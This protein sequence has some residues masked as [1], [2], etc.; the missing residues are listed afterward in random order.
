MP[1]HGYSLLPSYVRAIRRNAI[2]LFRR[3]LARNAEI[4]DRPRDARLHRALE[5]EHRR[6]VDEVPMYFLPIPL[7]SA[8]R[9]MRHSVACLSRLGALPTTDLR[10]KL[11]IQLGMP[12]EGDIVAF[13]R[14]RDTSVARKGMQ[15]LYHRKGYAAA[16]QHRSALIRDTSHRPSIYRLY[17]SIIDWCILGLYCCK[18]LQNTIRRAKVASVR[19][20]VSQTDLSVTASTHAVRQK[21]QRVDPTHDVFLKHA[22]FVCEV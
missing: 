13:R 21:L 1:S 14:F 7:A 17:C 18:R 22:H 9:W 4:K 20:E 2:S 19:S 16:H 10:S 3:A 6:I 15:I 5:E 12:P 11:T 8:R